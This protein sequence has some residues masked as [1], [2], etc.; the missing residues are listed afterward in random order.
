MSQLQP[1]SETCAPSATMSSVLLGQAVVG[2]RVVQRA[3]ASGI[4]VAIDADRLAGVVRLICAPF[5][6]PNPGM[7]LMYS[8]AL[9]PTWTKFCSCLVVSVDDFSPESTGARISA[10]PVTSTVWVACSYLSDT[11]TFRFSPPP[12]P[13]PSTL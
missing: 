8:A 10:E 12:I 5:W 2:E 13:M 9:V 4:A 7:I 11:L 3:L 6:M 1:G